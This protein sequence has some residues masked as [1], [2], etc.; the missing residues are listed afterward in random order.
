MQT[1]LKYIAFIFCYTI[2]NFSYSQEYAKE[3]PSKLFVSGG[4][5]FGVWNILGLMELPHN[6]QAD[7]LFTKKVVLGIG[8]SYDRYTRNPFARGSVIRQNIRLRYYSY[9]NDP[10]KRYSIFTGVCVGISFWE[11][12]INDSLLSSEKT[13][14]P[15][16]QFLSGFK[17]KINNSLF[18]LNEFAIGA[19]YSLQS[20]IGFNF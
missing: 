7:L 1:K 4:T 19:P 6:I 20:S 16:L 17:L 15:T 11:N 12:E 3:S 2:C 10:E 14:I 9:K 13:K 8:Y 5:H 18:W